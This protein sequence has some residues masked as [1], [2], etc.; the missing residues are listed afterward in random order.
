MTGIKEFGS[1][2]E[3]VCMCMHNACSGVNY[4]YILSTHMCVYVSRSQVKQI[5][6]PRIN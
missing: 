4:G 3:F 2:K 5:E 6:I 1:E